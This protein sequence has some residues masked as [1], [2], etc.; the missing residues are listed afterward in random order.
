[1]LIGRFGNTTGRPYIEGRLVLPRL[2]ITGDVSFLLDTGADVTYLTPGESVRL[3]IPYSELVPSA[4]PSFGVGGT[5]ADF[6]ET[7]YL[8]FA[9]EANLYVYQRDVHIAPL[10][11]RMMH[12]PALLGRNV[13]DNWEIRYKPRGGTLSCEVEVADA[14]FP[15]SE[16]APYAPIAPRVTHS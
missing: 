5:T 2:G 13:L 4:Q 12:L 1:M 7:C 9:D 6:I 14:V 8:A 16:I 3:R 15:L 11:Q 10:D